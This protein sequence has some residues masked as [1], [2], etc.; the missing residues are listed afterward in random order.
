MKL[1]L[2][3][4]DAGHLMVTSGKRMVMSLEVE[5]LR[6]YFTEPLK[7][8]DRELRVMFTPR[9]AAGAI[10]GAG[11]AA[12]VYQKVSSDN[13]VVNTSSTPL[14]FTIRLNYK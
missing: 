11:P 9:R 14:V 7:P 3:P 10:G 12:V 2:T 6:S 4:N 8:E 5:R 13:Y 1:E